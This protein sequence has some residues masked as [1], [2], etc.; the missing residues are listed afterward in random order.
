MNIIE[1]IEMIELTVKSSTMIADPKKVEL[2][3]ELKTLKKDVLKVLENVNKT[4]F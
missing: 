1:R 2:L 4:S 3:N